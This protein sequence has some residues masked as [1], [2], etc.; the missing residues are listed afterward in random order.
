MNSTSW[1][2][3]STSTSSTSASLR[4]GYYTSTHN[5]GPPGVLSSTLEVYD[6]IGNLV[7]V[8]GPYLA[9]AL[10]EFTV[11]DA[12]SD[13]LIFFSLGFETQG[14]AGA[15]TGKLSV[16]SFSMGD[17]GRN[18][19]L[20]SFAVIFSVALLAYQIL[21]PIIKVFLVR[22]IAN[23]SGCH[24]EETMKRRP[25]K[26]ITWAKCVSCKQPLLVKG[27]ETFRC[28]V[29]NAVQPAA[30][31]HRCWRSCIFEPGWILSFF[32]GLLGLLWGGADGVTL[33]HVSDFMSLMQSQ[34]T[35]YG[36]SFLSLRNLANL[37]N[38]HQRGLG[39]IVLLLTAVNAQRVFWHVFG[40]HIG[41]AWLQVWRRATAIFTSL[42]V[43]IVFVAVMCSWTIGLPAY[44]NGATQGSITESFDPPGIVFT[45]AQSV[46]WWLGRFIIL[47]LVALGIAVLL[48]GGSSSSRVDAVAQMLYDPDWKSVTLCWIVL[49]S[50]FQ[51][52]KDGGGN[53]VVAASSNAKPVDAEP[54]QKNQSE[55]IKDQ[56]NT[57]EPQPQQQSERSII[58]QEPK[59]PV[60]PVLDR[61]EKDEEL[62]ADPLTF[63]VDKLERVVSKLMLQLPPILE[64]AVDERV[65]FSLMEQ[66]RMLV[67]DEHE[68]ERARNVQSALSR[69]EEMRQQEWQRQ[70]KAMEEVDEFYYYGSNNENDDDEESDNYDYEE[71]DNG[72]RRRKI[73]SDGE[74][75]DSDSYSG[76]SDA[77]HENDIEMF[78]GSKFD[79]V[80]LLRTTSPRNNNSNR[81]G[82]T[83]RPKSSQRFSDST[84][85]PKYGRGANDF[86]KTR[87]S[88]KPRNL[89]VT[90]LMTRPQGKR[91]NK[92][93]RPNTS[94]SSNT[95]D[96][97]F[98]EYVDLHEAAQV[99]LRNEIVT[100]LGKPKQMEYLSPYQQ[101]QQQQRYR[102]DDDDD[103]NYRRNNDLPIAYSPTTFRNDSHV[104]PHQYRS[105]NPEDYVVQ[106]LL[107]EDEIEDVLMR[108]RKLPR[109]PR[110]QQRYHDNDD[111]GYR[112]NIRRQQQQKR[113]QSPPLG[114]G[115]YSGLP[116][117]KVLTEPKEVLGRPFGGAP[118]SLALPQPA[119]NPMT[120]KPRHY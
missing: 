100:A 112:N 43:L 79:P 60:D 50:W 8:P 58:S 101:Q 39:A 41:L 111:E 36:C 2:G 42:F 108:D 98:Q 26:T 28:D 45:W 82:I 87:N 5:G 104:S 37:M 88:S 10:A 29:C 48:A 35:Q 69:V 85:S 63:S 16:S 110:Q 67:L 115:R 40:G 68:K 17:D 119:Q 34:V 116:P 77:D 95:R 90:D 23:C 103:Y 70:S 73:G 38:L 19:A 7:K 52:K 56:Q 80:D 71:M 74:E 11:F 53:T 109:T 20:R 84:N 78:D 120:M 55:N 93:P 64:D 1:R 6:A 94:S 15:F 27:P 113:S 114:F 22:N 105:Q 12:S 91:S 44:R 66:S 18:I 102:D 13:S 72:K 118:S 75:Y 97:A 54:E 47:A 65:H 59:H 21:L 76:N 92:L 99:A 31:H 9:L 96:P 117:S 30:E 3:S 86:S 25:F 61:I 4:T 62:S 49:K 46:V 89:N 83:L 33:G 81:R 51:K 57:E 106:H 24:Y 32:C 14:G 107:D